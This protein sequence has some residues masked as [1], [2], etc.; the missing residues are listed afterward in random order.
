MEVV[1]LD[2]YGHDAYFMLSPTDDGYLYLTSPTFSTYEV[3]V[4]D[5]PT[6]TKYLTRASMLQ[7]N[8][9]FR[10]LA[11]NVLQADYDL[12]E[13]VAVYGGFIERDLDI[14]GNEYLLITVD[15]IDYSWTYFR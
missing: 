13:K 14:N 12:N 7:G 4:D 10:S 9:A 15:N 5:F 3:D 2:N 6:G 11:L 1:G 8:S